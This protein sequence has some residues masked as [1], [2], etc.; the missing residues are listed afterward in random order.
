M[1]D[2]AGGINGFRLLNI[3]RKKLHLRCFAGSEYASAID[4]FVNHETGTF[5][6]D[7]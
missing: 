4:V 3:L 1:R 5:H 7:I 2:G 6:Q